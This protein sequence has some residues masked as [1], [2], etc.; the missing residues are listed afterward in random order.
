MTNT[1]WSLTIDQNPPGAGMGELIVQNRRAGSYDVSD[2][3]YLL[4]GEPVEV[5]ITAI[6][7]T[8]GKHDLVICHQ[9]KKTKV[10]NKKQFLRYLRRLYEAHQKVHN[11]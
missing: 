7:A 4:F 1:I 9:R 10:R 3:L 5:N 6:D 11:A 8:L 2:D